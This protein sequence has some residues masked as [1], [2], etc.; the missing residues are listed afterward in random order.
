MTLNTISMPRILQCI[1]LAHA[2]LPNLQKYLLSILHS[3][4]A[5]LLSPNNITFI[6]SPNSVD[7]NSKL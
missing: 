5:D 2:S 4:N 6:A 1:S 7:R 3:I